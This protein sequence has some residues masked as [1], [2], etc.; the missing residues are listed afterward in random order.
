MGNKRTRQDIWGQ[1]MYKYFS[2]CTVFY[3]VDPTC[4]VIMYALRLVQIIWHKYHRVTWLALSITI[5]TV[6]NLKRFL[7]FYSQPIILVSIPNPQTS[8]PRITVLL[9]ASET[10]FLMFRPRKSSFHLTPPVEILFI[11]KDRR[12]ICLK[13]HSQV[14]PERVHLSS[15]CTLKST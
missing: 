6:L 7:L 1:K 2:Y 15:F 9:A 10:L 8:N 13:K 11:F 14:P 3:Q 5:F 12:P 4:T